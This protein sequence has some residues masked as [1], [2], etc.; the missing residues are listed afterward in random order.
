M[1]DLIREEMKKRIKEASAYYKQ[2]Q[3]PFF[4]DLDISESGINYQFFISFGSTAPLVQGKEGAISQV[5]V[6]L[7]TYRQGTRDKLSDFDEGYCEALLMK[8]LILDR[9]KIINKDYIKGVTGSD[10]IPSEIPDSQNVY[11]YETN[12]VF[13][14]SYGIGE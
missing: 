11:V 4:N 9:S 3:N 10:T 13:T 5:N 7:K 8:E 2:I 12:F 14:I 1:I 6:I